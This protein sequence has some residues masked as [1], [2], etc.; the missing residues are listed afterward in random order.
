MNDKLLEIKEF[1]TEGYMPLIHYEKWRVAVLRYCDELLPENI[2]K[3]Q[4]HDLTDEIFVLL[5]GHCTLFLAD[6]TDSISE[7]YVQS[8]ESL[9]IYNVKRGVWHSHTLSPDTT[10]LIIENDDTCDGNSP[11]CKLSSLQRQQL[12]HLVGGRPTAND[13]EV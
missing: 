4:R 5:A 10:V 7:I 12:I 9:K 6:G 13:V 11:E 3:L 8:L 2:T 1:T